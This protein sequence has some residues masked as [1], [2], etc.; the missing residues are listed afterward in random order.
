MY[1]QS[2]CTLQCSCYTDS[3]VVH[4]SVL[5]VLTVQL[6][7]TVFLLRTDGPVVHYSVLAVQTVQLYNGMFLLYRWYRHTL[8]CSCYTDGPVVQYNVL[9]ICT[10]SPVVHCSVLAVQTVQLYNTMFLLYRRF[11]CTLQCSCYVQTVQLYIT[12]F[13]LYRWYRH[14]LQCSCCTYSPVIPAVHNSQIVLYNAHPIHLSVQLYHTVFSWYIWSSC[15]VQCSP[16]TYYVFIL[17]TYSVP[18]NPHFSSL[19]MPLSFSCCTMPDHWTY[20]GLSPA[21]M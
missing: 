12:V 15:T 20:P 11:S 7:I 16:H 6:Y 10:D 4:Y 13:L 1:R 21:L 5:A 14:T 2:S 18:C 8:Q 19:Q 17:Y 3:L 9:A